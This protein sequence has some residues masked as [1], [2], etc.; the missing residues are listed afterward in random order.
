MTMPY[1][2]AINKNPNASVVYAKLM[3]PFFYYYVYNG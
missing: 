3:S 1:R 2:I